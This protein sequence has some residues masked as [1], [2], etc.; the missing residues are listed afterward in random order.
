MRDSERRSRCESKKRS[1]IE[2]IGRGRSTREVDRH[3][4]VVGAE[5]TS[6]T[7]RSTKTVEYVETPHENRLGRAS[8]RSQLIAGNG[9]D[10]GIDLDMRIGKPGRPDTLGAISL[11]WR[12]RAMI[13]YRGP[14]RC[15]EQDRPQRNR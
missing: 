12:E 10:R 8:F 14:G 15:R 1:V 7:V 11:K 9:L 3:C 4:D 6:T 13:R 2:L 5:N